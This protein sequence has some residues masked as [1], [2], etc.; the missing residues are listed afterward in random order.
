MDE[1]TVGLD[2]LLRKRC[3]HN[4]HVITVTLTHGI[5][6]SRFHNGLYVSQLPCNLRKQEASNT[7][8]LLY[9]VTIIATTYARFT[10]NT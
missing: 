6:S 3:V 9:T 5:L 4:Y 10:S 7:R 2:P 1:P 8:Y